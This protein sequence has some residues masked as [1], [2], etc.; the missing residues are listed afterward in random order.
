MSFLNS[1]FLKNQ[2]SL[3]SSIRA[4]A[5]TFVSLIAI[6]AHSSLGTPER[7]TLLTIHSMGEAI[8]MAGRQ[9][10]LSQR[11]AQSYFLKGL[12]P[13]SSR[14]DEQLQRAIREFDR[15]LESLKQYPPAKSLHQQALRVEAL[16]RP[17]KQLALGEVN[18]DS[19]T[20]LL[21]Q[22]NT[23]L[24]EANEYVSQLEKLSASQKAEIINLSG[25][26][27][28]LSQRIAKNFLAAQ[29][30]INTDNATAL[31]YEDL[32]EYENVLTYLSESSLNTPQ[33]KTQLHKV[34]GQFK[35]ALKGFDGAMSLS[36]KRLVH[37]VTG[38]T[39]A[40]LRG[41]NIITGQYAEL[42]SE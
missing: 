41:M 6:N 17:Y 22:S 28:M 36:G 12:K 21:E 42:L 9:R 35:Y 15:N 31:L 3:R 18:K 11:I 32:A 8:N 34:T 29:W 23:L 20:I 25:R 10:M 27:R 13:D 39:D 16:W 38:T 26:Q 4:L 14:S 1:V 24:K 7:S 19:G 30:G 37:V 5:I 2:P 40:M 33:I